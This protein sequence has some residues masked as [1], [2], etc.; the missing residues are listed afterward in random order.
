MH[1]RLHE[2]SI[3]SVIRSRPGFVAQLYLADFRRIY[4]ND[5]D[6]AL[7]SAVVDFASLLPLE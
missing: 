3:A 7:I 4:D 2:K 1:E 5:S 6:R